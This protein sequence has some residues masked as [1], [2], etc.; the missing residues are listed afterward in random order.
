MCNYNIETPDSR[1]DGHQKT[2]K[3]QRNNT[4][5]GRSFLL[6]LMPKFCLKRQLSRLTQ[7]TVE[8]NL[9]KSVVEIVKIQETMRSILLVVIQPQGV[10]AGIIFVNCTATAFYISGLKKSHY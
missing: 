6:A 4:K 1:I 8:Y 9:F 7:S 5:H 10:A 2:I 3:S